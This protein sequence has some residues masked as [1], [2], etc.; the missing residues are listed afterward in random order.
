[1]MDSAIA[2]VA[3]SKVSFFLQY[4]QNKENGAKVTVKKQNM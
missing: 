2:D 4:R 3:W 1:M